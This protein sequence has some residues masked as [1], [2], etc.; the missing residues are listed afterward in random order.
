MKAIIV[1]DDRRLIRY[2]HIGWPGSVHNSTMWASSDLHRHPEQHFSDNEYLIG[3]AGF[4][5]SCEHRLLVPYKR[6]KS[7]LPDNAKFNQLL[8]KYRVMIENLLGILKGRFPSLHGNRLRLTN[9]AD[10]ENAAMWDI[11]C[12]VLHNIVISLNNTDDN[13]EEYVAQEIDKTDHKRIYQS[14]EDWRKSIQAEVL[15]WAH[16]NEVKL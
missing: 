8:S 4:T 7:S 1:G 2:V 13:V 3:D 11:A 5:L 6:P 14:D 16:M 15:Q 9:P 10:C 12:M